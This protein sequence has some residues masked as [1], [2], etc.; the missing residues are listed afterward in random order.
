MNGF[1]PIHVNRSMMLLFEPVHAHL[2]AMLRLEQ[3]WPFALVI[4]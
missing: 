2:Q 4:A 3:Q 1:R